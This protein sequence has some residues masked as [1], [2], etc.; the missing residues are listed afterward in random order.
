MV[1]SVGWNLG[2]LREV[3]G[4]VKDTRESGARAEA[5]V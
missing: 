3:G 2:T 4:G 5:G 1:R